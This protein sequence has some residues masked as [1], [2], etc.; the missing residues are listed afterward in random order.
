MPLEKVS[1][2][3]GIILDMNTSQEPSR[4]ERLKRALYSRNAPDIMRDKRGSFHDKDFEVENNWESSNEKIDMKTEEDF[5]KQKR[6]VSFFKVFFAFA[7]VFFVCA[8][9]YSVYTYLNGGNSLSANNVD[10]TINGPVSVSGGDPVNLEVQVSNNNDIQLEVVDLN[11]E[12]PDGTANAENSAIALKRYQS[13]LGDIDAKSFTKHTV[14]AIFYGEEHTQKQVK[15]SVEYRV[16][17]SNAI[18]RKEKIYEFFLQ[19][20]PISLSIV[21]N[22]EVISGQNV[23]FEARLKS[24][25]EQI[26]KNVLLATQYPTGFTFKD[27]NV[28]PTYGNNVWSLGDIPPKGERIIKINGTILG[29]DEEE[30]IFRFNIGSKDV[31][32]EKII[33]TPF[34][35]KTQGITIQRPFLSGRLEFEGDTSS[36]DFVTNP[37]RTINAIL[38]YRNNLNV[39]LN[40]V[41]IGMT[42]SG[43]ALSDD[44]ILPGSGIYRTYNRTVTWTKVNNAKLSMLEPGEEGEITFSLSPI[45]INIGSSDMLKNLESTLTVN[46]KASRASE[47]SVPE[48]ITSSVIRKI[49]VLPRV[50]IAGQVVRTV[51]GIENTGPIPP[52]VDEKTTYTVIWTLT[53]TSSSIGSAVVE[54]YL[55]AYVDWTGQF[56]PGKEDITYSPSDKKITWKVGRLPPYTGVSSFK[57]Q[58]AFQIAVNPTLSHVGI[59]PNVLERVTFNG[60]D[61]FTGTNVMANHPELTS[62]FS[63]DPEF[64]DRDEQVVR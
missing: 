51:G 45:E 3:Y 15:V 42:F 24:N 55:P 62:K 14:S 8:I 26:L 22:N 28:K 6:H 49:K 53:T 63:S 32:D 19:S 16:P 9:A 21:S 48:N 18:L 2:S 20:S 60:V 61:E 29:Q 43:N 57:K 13:I 64:K 12:F 5:G 17:N 23:Q 39:N 25:S 52:K 47:N 36:S 40:D 1:Y 35:A 46:I 59:A 44:G 54:A 4:I 33:G 56:V 34:I 27:S 50:A 7:I 58:I 38:R 10:I 30:R 11:V 31:K 41:E 37:G